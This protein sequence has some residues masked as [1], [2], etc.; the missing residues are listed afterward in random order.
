M[1][2]LMVTVTVNESGIGNVDGGR[3]SDALAVAVDAA[4]DYDGDGDGSRSL[5]RSSVLNY[6]EWSVCSF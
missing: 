2:L 5:G 6:N 4:D 3:N 1:A